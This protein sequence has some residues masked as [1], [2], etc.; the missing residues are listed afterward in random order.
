VNKNKME[1]GRGILTKELQ[2][3]AN[4]R[5]GRDIDR[6][7]LRLIPYVQYVMVNDQKIDIE[8]INQDERK[9]LRKWKDAG[10]VE[11]G[12]SGLSVTKDFWDFACEILFQSYVKQEGE[13][14]GGI[15]EELD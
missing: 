2:E 5:I 1:V 7:E 4:R 11:G 13:E 3:I 8:K 6:T 12:A 14:I 9:I 15:K 10:L